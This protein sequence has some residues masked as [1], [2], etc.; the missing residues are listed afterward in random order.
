MVPRRTSG[1]GLLGD[2]WDRQDR[3]D[4]D[5]AD[6]DTLAEINLNLQKGFDGEGT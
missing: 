4:G 2:T 3:E 6:P 5:W 1:A